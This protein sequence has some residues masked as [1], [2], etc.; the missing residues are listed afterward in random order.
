[1]NELETLRSLLAAAMSAENYDKAR[2]YMY[3]I[4]S[5]EEGEEE[6]EAPEMED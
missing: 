2:Q 1:M 3:L 4:E 5:I 6:D